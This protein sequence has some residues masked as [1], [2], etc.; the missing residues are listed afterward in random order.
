MKARRLPCALVLALLVSTTA[1]AAPI[2]SPEREIE[3]LISALGASGCQ[4]QRNGSWHDAA[5]AQAHLRKKYAYLHKRHMVASAEQFIERAGSESSLSGR[6]YQVRCPG[7][8]PV[9]SAAWLRAKLAEIRRTA[10]SR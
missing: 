4:F 9:A 5:Q 2:A 1:A 3:Q 7:R 10:P 6:A 8:P